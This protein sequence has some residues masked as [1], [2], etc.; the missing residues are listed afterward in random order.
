MTNPFILEDNHNT[1]M[2][3]KKEF[4]NTIQ[5]LLKCQIIS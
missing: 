5:P 2:T 1:I 3:P 4:P